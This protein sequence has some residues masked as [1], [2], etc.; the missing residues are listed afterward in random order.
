MQ[1]GDNGQYAI[2]YL[3]KM[4]SRNLS[5]KIQKIQKF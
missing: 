5:V 4:P 2:S 3:L 1:V